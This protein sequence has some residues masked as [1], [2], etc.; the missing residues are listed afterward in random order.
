MAA[1]TPRSRALPAVLV[2]GAA[3]LLGGAY[4]LPTIT[5]SRLAK[6][7]Q[8]YS[9]YGG[10]EALWDSSNYVLAAIV[11]GFSIVFPIAKLCVLSAVLVGRAER[12]WAHR[13]RLL[14]KWSMVDVFVIAGFIGAVRVGVASGASRQGI[15]LFT[16]G[17]VVSMLAAMATERWV[18]GQQRERGSGGE[19]PVALSG[20]PEEPSRLGWLLAASALTAHVVALAL[21]L[22]VVIVEV[23][24]LRSSN[25]MSL[26]S[27]T[28]GLAED[29]EWGL[30]GVLLLTVWALP[31]LRAACSLV[32]SLGA[33]SPRWLRAALWLDE[34]SMMPVFALGLVVVW[35]KLLDLTTT[36]LMAGFSAVLVAALLGELDAWRLRRAS[37]PSVRPAPSSP[38]GDR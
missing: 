1:E 6:A 11:F 18:H 2:L 24:L 13:L 37:N 36:E 8:T 9:I 32:W 4:S 20:E 21:P 25:R 33:R 3:F 23:F 34:W 26:R 27:L 19:E 29:H 28:S 7:D 38:P 5:Y 12:G 17:V 16:A 30:A 15:H 14:G 22:L 35:V 10:A 31:L